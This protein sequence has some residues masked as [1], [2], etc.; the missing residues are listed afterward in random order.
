VP[1]FGGTPRLPPLHGRHP[2][3]GPGG[4]AP[5]TLFFFEPLTVPRPLRAEAAA[6]PLSE[7]GLVARCQVDPPSTGLRQP[8]AKDPPLHEEQVG[9]GPPCHQVGRLSWDFVPLRIY[10]RVQDRVG[11]WLTRPSEPDPCEPDRPT[12]ASPRVRRP[13]SSA[14]GALLTPF[15]PLSRARRTFARRGVPSVTSFR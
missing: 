14:P 9:G 2:R 5:K 11:V 1:P 13:V 3:R 4:W 15:L 6:T 7:H 12:N 8:G 10:C